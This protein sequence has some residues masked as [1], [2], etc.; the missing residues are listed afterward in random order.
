MMNKICLIRMMK[1]KRG[2]FIQG[3]IYAASDLAYLVLFYLIEYLFA[4]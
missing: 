4:C 1:I 3:M 2:A